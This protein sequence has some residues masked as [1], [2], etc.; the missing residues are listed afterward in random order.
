[1]R[2]ARNR[3]HLGWLKLISSEPSVIRT[4]IFSFPVGLPL[5]CVHLHTSVPVT[6]HAIL[7][8]LVTQGDPYGNSCF[9]PLEFR[10]QRYNIYPV[11]QRRD[12]FPHFLERFSRR[13]YFAGN[14]ITPN[15]KVIYRYSR[16]GTRCT[17]GVMHTLII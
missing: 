17:R 14:K 3:G 8:L 16:C 11:L 9:R 1:M 15:E 12:E 2:K 7:L 13:L 10:Q 5:W 6:T 4:F